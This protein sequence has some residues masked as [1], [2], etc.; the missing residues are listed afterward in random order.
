M[1]SFRIT[2]GNVAPWLFLAV[3]NRMH[4]T[5]TPGS[6][7]NHLAHHKWWRVQLYHN[8]YSIVFGQLGHCCLVVQYGNIIWVKSGL[9]NGL[10]GGTKPSFTNF[11]NYIAF[12]PKQFLQCQIP[13]QLL[14]YNQRTC[15]MKLRNIF[16]KKENCRMR[17]FWFKSMSLK[18][19]HMI[20][21]TLF[22]LEE[23]ELQL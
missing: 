5:I 21:V 3:C 8:S 1:G 20:T 22:N 4:Y 7:I 11:V 14:S 15:K 2:G 17:F 6:H 19:S 9:C 16:C 10:P 13:C 18:I 23:R 12:I